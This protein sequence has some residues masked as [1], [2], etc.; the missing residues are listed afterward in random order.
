M[1]DVVHYSKW[2]RETHRWLKTLNSLTLYDD[3]RDSERLAAANECWQWVELFLEK[4]EGCISLSRPGSDLCK[5]NA[6]RPGLWVPLG[7]HAFELVGLAREMNEFTGGYFNPATMYLTDL[8]G[9]SPRTFAA[10]YQP[11]RPYDRPRVA[12]IME[13]PDR[14]YVDLF[15]KT[16]D[17][18]GVAFETRRGKSGLVKTKDPVCVDGETYQLGVDL[19]GIAKGWVADAV[20]SMVRRCGFEYAAYSCE[21]SIAMTKSASAF[22]QQRGDNSY[23]VS[24]VSPRQLAGMSHYLRLRRCDGAVATSGDYGRCY[25]R[26]GVVYS[27]IIDPTTGMPLNVTPSMAYGN[28]RR[29]RGLCTVTLIGPNAAKADALATALCLMGPR[30]AVDFYNTK[31]AS[32]NWDMVAVVY[33]NQRPSDLGLITSLPAGSYRVLDCRVSLLSTCDHGKICLHGN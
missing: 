24:L 18:S 28:E 14:Q 3:F 20:L 25:T 27:H 7:T 29:Q 22:A 8:W 10:D 30:G 11:E 17:L 2:T 15:L 12:G 13:P 23:T 26:D 1:A 32:D 31:L 4:V 21:S 6:A 33:D 9:F 16:C 5:F 19:G